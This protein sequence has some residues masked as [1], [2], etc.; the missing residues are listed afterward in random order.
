MVVSYNVGCFMQ[1]VSYN[2][3]VTYNVDV[4][5]NANYRNITKE[6]CEDMEAESKRGNRHRSVKCSKMSIILREHSSCTCEQRRHRSVS[7]L[8]Q[9]GQ[10]HCLC[11]GKVWFSQNTAQCQ[12]MYHILV[13]LCTNWTTLNYHF[14]NYN[15]T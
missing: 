15:Q 4:S 12:R 11:D 7:T 9:T 10:Q 8:V 14:I 2:V 5:Y 1:C 3:V 6:I 13:N